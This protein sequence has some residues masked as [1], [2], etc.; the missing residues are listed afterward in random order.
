MEQVGH[1]L[2]V[3]V[4]RVRGQRRVDV[5]V[6]IHPHD[7]QLPNRRRVPVDGTDRQAEDG[8]HKQEVSRWRADTWNL[9][10]DFLFL[11]GLTCGLRPA[12]PPC[13]RPPSPLAPPV[14]ASG[15]RH[16]PPS[17]S[18]A[19]PGARRGTCP[20]TSGSHNPSL[21]SL[22]THTIIAGFLVP[23]V[24]HYQLRRFPA[25]SLCEH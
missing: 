13:A 1:R 10:P 3:D 9:R 22:H 7:A 17:R 5:G 14:T 2:P 18:S 4:P 19:S 20:R 24:Q 25:C 12:P 8:K 6:S 23:T 21:H 15:W 16:P 11:C